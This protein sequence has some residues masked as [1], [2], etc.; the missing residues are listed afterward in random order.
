VIGEGELDADAILR[1]LVEAGIDFVVVGGFAVA[2]HG[3]VRATKDVDIVPRPT[4]ENRARLERVLMSIGARPVE[5][6]E[7]RSEELPVP[8]EIGAL[9][10]GGNWALQT[11]HGRIDILQYIDRVEFVESYSELH[12]HALQTVLSDVGAVRFAALEHLL[13]MKR[14][15]GRPKDLNDLAQ[16]AEIGV[17]GA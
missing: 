6:T 3:Y 13:V 1:T 15:A 7:F 8:W 10:H 2:A 5:Q 11:S 4:A 14:A 16:L 17:G 9:A 12:D